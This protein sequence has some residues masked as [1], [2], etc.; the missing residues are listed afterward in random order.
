M[1]FFAIAVFV[2]FYMVRKACM[3]GDMDW[4]NYYLLWIIAIVVAII[5][6]ISSCS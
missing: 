1:I 6:L 3:E 4:M 2:I 5:I